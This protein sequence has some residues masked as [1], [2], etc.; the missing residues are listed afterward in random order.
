MTPVGLHWGPE[1]VMLESGCG[2]DLERGDLGLPWEAP[3][4]APPPPPP[5]HTHTPR[6]P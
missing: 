3:L 4:Q 2:W 5:S 6:R 1:V